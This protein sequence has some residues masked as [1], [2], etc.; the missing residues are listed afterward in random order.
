VNRPTAQPHL[1]IS[2]DVV[3]IAQW[4]WL[5]MIISVMSSSLP[6]EGDETD[7]GQ[8]SSIFE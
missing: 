1:L 2:A 4:C 6:A 8:V 3:S 5:P 7:I